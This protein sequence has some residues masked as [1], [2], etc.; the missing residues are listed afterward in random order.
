MAG[1]VPRRAPGSAW[2]PSCGWDAGAEW[3]GHVARDELP[4]RFD[5]PGGRVW[6][7]NNAPAPVAELPF[8][9]EFLDAYRAARIG[10]FLHASDEH[11]PSDMARLQVDRTSQ[12]FIVLARHLAGLQAPGAREGRLIQ[13]VRDWDGRAEVDSV[14]AAIVGVTYTR[15]LDAVVRAKLGR[16]SA[17]FFD[18]VHAVPNLN[19][20]AARAAS[21]VIGLLEEAPADWFGP[22][23]ASDDSVSGR[24]VWSA[25]LLRCFRDAV[26][27]L[28]ERL[29][30]DESRWTW[31]RV[32]RVTL[33]HG[34][35]DVPVLA[36]LFDLG[37]YAIGSDSQAPLQAGPMTSDPFAPVTAVPAL[38]LVIDMSDP[39]RAE[40]ALAGGQVGR[41][42][43]AHATD[44]LPDWR[45]G[46]L[47]PLLTMRAA[48][49]ADS[50]RRLR[51]EPP[52]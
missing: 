36:K 20:V 1:A 24:D 6:T 26:A 8:D 34:L 50:R 30:A 3:R 22:A 13:R 15:L 27:L 47:R 49:Q 2:L 16:D 23:P 9:G 40:F 14:P 31:G 44:L 21:L 45:R 28:E 39:P 11:S 17:A 42:G 46:R 25:V 29:G 48:V 37:P 5:P 4:H 19:F 12:S 18:D 32:R 33:K 7:A 43:D 52:G 41:R 35:A 38:R 10:E 51:L